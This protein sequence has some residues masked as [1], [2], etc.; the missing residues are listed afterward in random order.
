MLLGGYKRQVMRK[1]STIP[2]LEEGYIF[3]TI[4][5]NEELQEAKKRLYMVQ[6]LYSSIEVLEVDYYGRLEE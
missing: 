2:K 4:C 5:T 3:F 1:I 6:R